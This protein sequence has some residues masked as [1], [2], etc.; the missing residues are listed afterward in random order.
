MESF[1]LSIYWYEMS[2]LRQHWGMS[3]LWFVGCQNQCQCITN[4]L[5]MMNIIP[6]FDK[7]SRP[8]PFP[9]FKYRCCEGHG[10]TLVKQ[11]WHQSSLKRDTGIDIQTMLPCHTTA[12]WTERINFVTEERSVTRLL[13]ITRCSTPGHGRH[14]ASQ[15]SISEAR[16]C[17]KF[18]HFL[19]QASIH[20]THDWRIYKDAV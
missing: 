16:T 12:F 13:N 9:P 11:S 4:T 7:M 2:L 17:L 6:S 5:Q 15:P 14:S 10:N 3:A 8:S 20:P 1:S 18:K 19:K